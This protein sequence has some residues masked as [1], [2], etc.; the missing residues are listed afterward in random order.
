[1]MTELGGNAWMFGYAGIRE[2]NLSMNAHPVMFHH[3]WRI[4]YLF[5]DGHVQLL[6]ETPHPLGYQGTIAN[7]H[8]GFWADGTQYRGTG[9]E[10]FRQRFPEAIR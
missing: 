6:K 4:N 2:G 7:P 1:M 5:M 10:G 8:V 9:P 3:N